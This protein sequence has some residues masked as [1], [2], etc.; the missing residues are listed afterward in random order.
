MPKPFVKLTIG[1]FE[2][3]VVSYNW[4]RKIDAVHMH[5][6]WRPNHAQYRGLASIESMW[7]FHTQE[8]RW[9]D[10]AQ[11]I[12][13][14]PDGSIWTGRNWNHPPASA[15]GYNGNSRQG[16]FMFEMIGDFDEGKD[17]FKDPQRASVIRV[18]ASVLQRFELPT[19]ALHF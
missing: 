11:H 4:T 19:S 6:T 12:S 15:L 3:L 14:A 7:E 8:R 2:E 17:P 10:I 16:P 5:H 9:S 1:Q 18:I 13:I